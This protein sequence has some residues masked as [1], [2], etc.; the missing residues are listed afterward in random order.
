MAAEA[1]SGQKCLE[2]LS[3]LVMVDIRECLVDIWTDGWVTNEEPVIES[4]IITVKDYL[5]DLTTFLNP[6][7]SE[8]ILKL[9][10]S[11]IRLSIPILS[12]GFLLR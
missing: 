11:S 6:F 1:F 5:S 10:A 12:L 8:K 2:R 7:W 3:S 4:I 9:I